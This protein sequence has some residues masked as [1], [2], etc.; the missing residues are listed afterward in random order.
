M[1]KHFS[2]L[3]ILLLF[4]IAGCSSPARSALPE[5][6]ADS[7]NPALNGLNRD[8]AQSYDASFEV[9][10]EGTSRWTYALKTRKTPTLSELSLHIDGIEG[11][12]NPGD[13]RLVTDGK[14]SWVS[15]QGTDQEC[16][17]FPNGQGMDPQWI[18]P[19]SLLSMQDLSGFMKFAG[20]ENLSGQAALHYVGTTESVGGWKNVRAE[21]WQGKNSSGLLRYILEGQVEDPFF[22]AGAGKMSARY[23]ASVLENA[24]IE[25]VKGC[26]I[27][28]PLPDR[29]SQYV[30]LPGMASFITSMGMVELQ[31]FYQQ[32]LPQQGWAEKEVPAIAEGS[33]VLSYQ[34][35]GEE[36]EIHILAGANGGSEVK[37]LFTKSK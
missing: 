30:R 23:E 21:V 5:A 31:G 11:P 29:I 35:N 34:R 16:M 17:Q 14:T 19:E 8:L 3:S 13:I 37:M 28:V 33:V 26:E 25:P 6:K 15:G 24:V 32:G 4:V 10:F 7:A 1:K 20:E 2:L 18:L 36:V 9:K 22:G 27:N 12:N